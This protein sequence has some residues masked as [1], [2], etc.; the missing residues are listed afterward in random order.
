M[1]PR[2]HPFPDG[3]ETLNRR[4][5]FEYCT[6]LGL[7][8]GLAPAHLAASED[9]EVDGAITTEDMARAERLF[10]IELT[11]EERERIVE[12]V[13]ENVLYYRDLR[14][15][16]L[17][18]SVNLSLVFNP[19]PPGMVMAREKEPVK[20]SRLSAKRPANVED[21]A[22]YSVLQLASLI[23]TRQIT[24]TE[25]TKMYLSRLRKH[26]PLLNFVITF[27][28][29]L[30]LEQAQ[31]ADEEI[32]SGNYRGPL[33]GI[34][35]GVKDLFAVQGYKTTWG[36]EPF[37]DQVIDRTATA[38]ERLEEAGAVLMAKLS[39]GRLASGDTWFG[40]QTKRAW[41]PAKGSGGSS[42]GPASA[43][44]AGCVAFALGTETNGSIISPCHMNGVTGF[45]PTF[46]R[47][48][49][50]GVMTLCWS[51]DKVGTICRAVEDC[52]VVLEA[53]H[54]PDGKD[55]SVVDLP[56]NWDSDLDISG[57]RVG[58][59]SRSFE[60]EPMEE[61]DDPEDLAYQMALRRLGRG[62]LEFFRS[63]GVELIPLDFDIPIA[64]ADM[65]LEIEAAT[66]FDELTRNNQDDLLGESSW[67]DTF[68]RMRYW[69]AI[70]YIQA[71]RYRSVICEQIHKALEDVDVYIETTWSNNWL[72]NM[73]G[74]PA[75][76]VPCGFVKE[77][78]PAGITF[79][80]HLY[81]EAEML[82]VAKSFQDGTDHHLQHPS[83]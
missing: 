21:V 39:M 13:N 64:G 49:R 37:R 36:A 58:Y 27:T 4:R 76:V 24:S 53:I 59:F 56:F 16:N 33:H 18:N 67:P 57:L 22:Y 12:D 30:A 15:R 50:H 71:N 55:N 63:R 48:S 38:V 6:A 41:D 19:I 28:D 75:I 17:D 66:A 68:R 14:E 7:G 26:N 61:G 78:Q 11:P 35:Y 34:P 45:R 65:I 32:S 70:E 52:A 62:V 42:A 5:F 74:H 1:T 43:T 60:E 10:D 46:G 44:A 3:K 80:G 2:L 47:V 29:D 83:L 31:R 25:L 79:V 72:T 82:A 20:F 9:E 40:G 23:E 77:R 81:R 54:G 8:A 69:P 73:T 51:L